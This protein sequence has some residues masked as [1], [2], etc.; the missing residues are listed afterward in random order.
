MTRTYAA[1]RL[2]EHGPLSMAQFKEIT[3]W[4]PKHSCNTIKALLMSGA[5]VATKCHRLRS[6]INLYALAS[7]TTASGYANG[8]QTKQTASTNDAGRACHG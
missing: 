7:E 5:V 1:R 6:E 4:N 8:T 3:G 2:L